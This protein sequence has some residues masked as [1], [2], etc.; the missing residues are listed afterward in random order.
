MTVAQTH[1]LPLH[2]RVLVDQHFEV[3]GQPSGSAGTLFNRF[4][5]DVGADFKMFPID[6]LDWKKVS[7]HKRDHAWNNIVKVRI[8]YSIS[9]V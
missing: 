1:H 3:T 9:V 5:R 6:L 2:E 4:C 7:D 8:D